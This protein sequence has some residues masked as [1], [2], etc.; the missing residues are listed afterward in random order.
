MKAYLKERGY[1]WKIRVKTLTNPFGGRD[2]FDITLH[3]DEIPAG[4][5]MGSSSSSMEKG[6]TWFST[7]Q[8]LTAGKI[9]ELKLHF[10]GG[11][12]IPFKGTHHE[13]NDMRYCVKVHDDGEAEIWKQLPLPPNTVVSFNT[14]TELLDELVSYG[15]ENGPANEAIEKL[16]TTTEYERIDV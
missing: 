11:M 4:V 8:G 1:L 5:S 14:K 12:M 6:M 13:C 7:D 3:E 9:N 10:S 2:R 16:Q 15:I